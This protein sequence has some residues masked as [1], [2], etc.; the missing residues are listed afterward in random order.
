MTSPTD[1][2][3]PDPSPG[4]GPAPVPDPVSPGRPGP[5]PGP[6]PAPEP[7]PPMVQGAVRPRWLGPLATRRA[8]REAAE[9]LEQLAAWLARP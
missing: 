4:P 8:R 9:G 7:L 6:G 5:E 3:A 1:P 2:F